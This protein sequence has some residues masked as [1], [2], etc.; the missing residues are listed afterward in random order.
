MFNGDIPVAGDYD[1]EGKLISQSSAQAESSAWW[2]LRST[3][4][5]IL[6]GPFGFTTDVPLPSAF[7]R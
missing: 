7:V 3:D 4:N 5:G 1:A 2:V 6:V